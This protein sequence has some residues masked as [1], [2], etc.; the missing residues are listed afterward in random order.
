MYSGQLID[1]LNK[2]QHSRKIFCGVKALD[3]VPRHRVRRPCA[4]V[5]NTH[6]SDQSGEHWFG[7]FVPR[8]WPIEYFDT[9][10]RRPGEKQI[11]NFFQNIGKNF[12]HNHKRIQ[13]DKSK[14]CGPFTLLYICFRSRGYTMQRYLKFF[15]NTDFEYND[16]LIESLLRKIQSK[17]MF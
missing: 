5:V 15:S 2:D 1:L 14:N 16:K 7:E 6:T 4:F 3:Q 10:A 12:V 17:T 11:F 8:R 13:S 9:Y